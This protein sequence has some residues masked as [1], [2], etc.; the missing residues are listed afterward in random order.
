[1]TSRRGGGKLERGE[2]LALG[3]ELGEQ[4][5]RLERLVARALRIKREPITDVRE[6]DLVGMEHRAAAPRRPAVA[7]DPD[8][9]DVAGPICD[10]SMMICSTSGSGVG[11]REPDW[12]R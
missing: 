12:Y 1:M 4:R 3:R 2:A 6:P 10:A 7:V 11:V 9:V 8:H 5:R